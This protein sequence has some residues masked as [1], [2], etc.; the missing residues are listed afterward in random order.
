[1]PET[2]T[3]YVFERP[4]RTVRSSLKPINGAE[5]LLAET[6]PTLNRKSRQLPTNGC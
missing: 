4:I 2:T 1:M 6:V 3:D 5:I